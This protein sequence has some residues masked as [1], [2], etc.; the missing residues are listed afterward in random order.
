[1]NLFRITRL[2]LREMIRRKLVITAVALSVA[3]ALATGLGFYDLVHHGGHHGAPLAHLQVLTVSALM[4]TMIAYMFNLIFALGGAFV[5][6]PTLAGDIESGLLLPL[7]TRPVR[8]TEIVLGK[9]IGIAVLLCAY[10]FFV[11]FLE[12]GIVR[13]VTS[14]LPPHPVIALVYL[15]GVGVTMLSLALLLSSRMAAI[16]SGV[17]AVVL[18]GVAWIAGV[19]G[20]IGATV[21]SVRFADVGVVS[22][23][24]LP[25]DAFWRAAV[26]H[27]EP[28]AMI[29]GLHGTVPFAVSAPPPLAT[30]VWAIGWIVLMVALACWSL[31]TRD[32]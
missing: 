31:S 28:A 3:V 19:V 32:L 25:S 24:V 22:E 29:L 21:H 17:A 1:M 13:L 10:A 27:L 8:R 16:S 4:V 30:I 20:D 11:G 18:Y 26:Y 12:F 23:L 5:A 9:F 15:C 14:Y 7:A 6:A 2:T